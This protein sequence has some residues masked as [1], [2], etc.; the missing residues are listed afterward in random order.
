MNMTLSKRGDYVMRSAI[1]LARAFDS[2][3][4]RKIR[5]VVAE[6][7]L[8]RTFA[9]QILADLVRAGLAVSKAGR[10]GGYWL[11]RPP[12]EISVL[13]VVEAAEG[14]LHAERCAL[15]DGPCRWETV[16]PL[17]ETWVAA[18][19]R[20]NGLLAE[21]SLAEVARRDEAIEAG[22]YVTPADSHRARPVEIAMDDGVHV[23]LAVADVADALASGRVDAG[24][25]IAAAAETGLLSGRARPGPVGDS[26]QVAEWSLEEVGRRTRGG[27]ARFTLTWR[28]VGA[29]GSSLFQGKLSVQAVDDERSEMRAAGAWHQHVAGTSSRPDAEEA[30][31]RTLRRFLRRVAALLEE[32]SSASPERLTV[33]RS[34]SRH[35]RRADAGAAR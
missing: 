22:N 35:R 29:D 23:E 32:G 34:P 5:E 25:L 4:P 28:L 12:E 14:P 21:T 20:L 26:P 30:A 19:A 3:T 15:G 27:S 13:E 33:N 7:D 17:H 8:P 2:G 24:P 9:S 11:A 31:R 16:C 18:T 1:A 6:T 10:D